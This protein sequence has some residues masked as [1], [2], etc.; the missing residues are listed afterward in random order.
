MC[1]DCVRARL[2]CLHTFTVQFFFRSTQIILNEAVMHVFVECTQ[3]CACQNK[4]YHAWFQKAAKRRCY[5]HFGNVKMTLQHV[6]L[7]HSY[8]HVHKSYQLKSLMPD[9]YIGL[10]ILSA[11]RRY[12]GIGVYIP[13]YA[14]LLKQFFKATKNA[15]MSD[16]KM[17]LLCSLSSREQLMLCKWSVCC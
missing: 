10:S 14:P 3:L 1:A 15:W 13:R 8:I 16:F 5:K 4:M 7:F 9:Q 2:V 11:Y 12:T 6:G 17:V